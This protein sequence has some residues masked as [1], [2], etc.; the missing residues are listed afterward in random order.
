MNQQH[1]ERAHVLSGYSGV[2][3][4]RRLLAEF[5]SNSP[6]SSALGQLT[7]G[8][9]GAVTPADVGAILRAGVPINGL[10]RIEYGDGREHWETALLTT[11]IDGHH[12]ASQALIVYGAD[13]EAPCAVVTPG[14]GSF[15][16]TALHM[17]VAQEDL[18]AA[19]ILVGSG[20]DVNRQTTLGTTAL[21]MAASDDNL[22]LVQLLTSLGADPDISDF[23]G[24]YPR[25]VAGARTPRLLA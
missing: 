18:A 14:K 7:L 21:F 3:D 24:T 4:A 15:C 20:A 10:R 12:A 23:Q 9:H 5:E 2:D 8:L 25:D 17:V 11:L 13:V 6:L 19:K 1:V 16:H 22:P